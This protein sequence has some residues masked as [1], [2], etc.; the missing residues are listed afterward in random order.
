M[1]ALYNVLRPSPAAAFKLSSSLDQCF[2]LSRLLVCQFARLPVCPFASLPVMA[3][4]D[5]KAVVDLASLRIKAS[6]VIMH[7]CLLCVSINVWMERN[8]NYWITGFKRKTFQNHRIKTII[9]FRVLTMM[10]CHITEFKHQL[11]SFHSWF[12]TLWEIA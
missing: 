2:P 10:M 11:A 5:C 6:S 12:G 8:S 7:F 4:N 9:T 1:R 3:Y